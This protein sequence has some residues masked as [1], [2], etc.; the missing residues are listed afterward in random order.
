MI[1]DVST[2]VNMADN[3]CKKIPGKVY[4]KS[5]RASVCKLFLPDGRKKRVFGEGQYE[6]R[7]AT[8]GSS[9]E[10]VFT[11]E[12]ISNHDNITND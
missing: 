9:P 11:S 8:P 10:N 6:F 4:K 7:L 12:R 1:G 5:S 2:G 3:L